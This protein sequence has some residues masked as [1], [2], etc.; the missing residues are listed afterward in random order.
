[1]AARRQTRHSAPEHFGSLAAD[2]PQRGTHVP[3]ERGKNV[4]ARRAF[5][6]LALDM[7]DCELELAGMELERWRSGV[8][9]VS[10]PEPRPTLHLLPKH[11]EMGVMGMTE[12]LTGIQLLEGLISNMGKPPTTIAHAEAFE[13]TFGF[14]YN[15]IYDRQID[16][17]KRK[18]CNLTKTLDAMKA[19]IVKEH[20]RRQAEKERNTGG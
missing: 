8:P 2:L 19:A 6:S 3:P 15:D 18:P 14:S 16:L 12:I 7:V 4:P 5:V 13:R 17:F 9:S 20:R 11:R 10:A 1:M